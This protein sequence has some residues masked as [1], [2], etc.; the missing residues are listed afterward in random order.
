VLLVG[1]FYDLQM[2][3]VASSIFLLR[4][5]KFVELFSENSN[6]NQI[7]PINIYAT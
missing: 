3:M 2:P 6:G 4:S 5:V 7:R 1:R